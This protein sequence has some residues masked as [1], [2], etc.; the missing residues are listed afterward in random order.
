MILFNCE[1]H[2]AFI[3]LH[4]DYWAKHALSEPNA[5]KTWF[6][7]VHDTWGIMPDTEGKGGWLV[8]DETKYT[9]FIIKWS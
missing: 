6:N 5:L 2:E 1:R 8:I 3:N 9:L 4:T 7:Y